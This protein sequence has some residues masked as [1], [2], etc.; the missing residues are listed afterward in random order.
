MRL[1]KISERKNFCYCKVRALKEFNVKKAKIKP[2]DIVYV[3]MYPMGKWY[4]FN[5]TDESA[6]K[7]YELMTG[8]IEGVDFE[9]IIEE[10]I[11]NPIED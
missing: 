4:M 6:E 3:M 10:T 8:A 1:V 2:G 9:D 7:Q 5:T 11:E